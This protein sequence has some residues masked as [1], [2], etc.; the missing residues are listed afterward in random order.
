MRQ[1]EGAVLLFGTVCLFGL[2]KIAKATYTGYK[3]SLEEL[4]KLEQI[5]E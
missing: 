4:Q 5:H 1:N 3:D 2:Y